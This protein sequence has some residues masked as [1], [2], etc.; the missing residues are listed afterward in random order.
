MLNISASNVSHRHFNCLAFSVIASAMIVV[1]DWC[2][3]CYCMWP[4]QT[5]T[6]TVLCTRLYWLFLVG[7][8]EISEQRKQI[9]FL[10]FHPHQFPSLHIE[11]IARN[12]CPLPTDFFLPCGGCFHAT[13]LI[14]PWYNVRPISQT[15][16]KLRKECWA[17]S[18]SQTC[19]LRCIRCVWEIIMFLKI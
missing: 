15:S 3:G 1:P 6:F 7:N 12:F 11:N 19:S 5:K 17:C 18:D 9:S 16:L 13:S 10:P 4:L 2:F 14:K 8:K